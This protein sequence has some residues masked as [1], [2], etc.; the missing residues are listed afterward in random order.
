MNLPSASTLIRRARLVS[1]RTPAAAGGEPIDLRIAGGVVTEVGMG[2]RASAD[3]L[4]IE[5]D[6]RWA[7]PGLWD[8]HVHL[9]QWARTRI[10]VD[11]GGSTSPDEVIARIIQHLRTVP[12]DETGAVF[13]FGFRSAGW[14][15]QPTVEELD[16][17]VADRPVVL[18]SGD[19]HN[20]WLNSRALEA[21]GARP[22]TGPLE[23]NEWFDICARLDELPAD[24]AVLERAYHEAAAD[25]AVKGVV[26]IVDMEFGRGFADWPVRTAAGVDQLRVRPAAYADRLDEV[27][28]A[29]LRGG[30]VLD[31][32]GLVTMGPLKIIS[33]GSLNTR[34]AYCCDPYV[35][36]TGDQARG[37]QNYDAD[38]LTHLL[39][40]AHDHGLRVAV[41]A[42]GD[43][44]AS[45]ALDAFEQTGARGTIEH[46]QLV[47]REDL[48]RMAALGV[49]A[50]VQPAH[51]LDD[52]EITEQIW[53]DRADRCFLLRSM[54]E[55]GVSLAFGSDAPVAALDPWLAM[56]AA[57]H[58]GSPEAEPWNPDEAVTPAL[59]LASSTDGQDTLAE[60]SLGDVV[61]LDADPLEAIAARG[62]PRAAATLLAGRPTHLDL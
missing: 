61:L 7:I 28:D 55:A 51:L 36:G 9:G 48:P 12:S 5:A 54:H 17:A 42:I 39:A 19:V 56:T 14:A 47:R 46:A 50:S 58:R 38:E 59:A 23:E 24:P 53:A 15:R 45:I 16:L 30:Q 13:G 29:G 41:H 27:I 60:G 35:S 10:Q 32:A 8:Q 33:D 37:K 57:V 44:A 20:G 11:L 25:A 22:A 43:A 62:T 18:I 31:E 6:G 34:T 49:T 26:G 2:L 52:L 1:V 3:E 21:F 4:V 40:R